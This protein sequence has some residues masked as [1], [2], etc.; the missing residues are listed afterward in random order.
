MLNS[1]SLSDLFYHNNKWLKMKLCGSKLSS[2]FAH[3]NFQCFKTRL[4][5]SRLV[6]FSIKLWWRNVYWHVCAIYVSS[7]AFWYLKLQ[8][9]REASSRSTIFSFS[10]V[11]MCSLWFYYIA[12]KFRSS[13]LPIVECIL[14]VGVQTIML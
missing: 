6:S 13:V 7:T 14:I 3:F 10:L 1:N 5:N 8:N 4:K 11:S 12:K 9:L 2:F